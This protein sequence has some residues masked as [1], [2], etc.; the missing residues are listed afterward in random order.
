MI[1]TDTLRALVRSVL[2]QN[3]LHFPEE[4]AAAAFAELSVADRAMAFDLTC[5]EFVRRTMSSDSL[6]ARRGH[7]VKDPD[8][9]E[10]CLDENNL[11]PPLAER[12]SGV[13]ESKWRLRTHRDGERRHELMLQASTCVSRGVYKPFGEFTRADCCAAAH[14]RWGQSAANAV[15]AEKFELLEKMQADAGVDGVDKLSA[16]DL[17]I[18]KDF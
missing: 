16:E 13:R 11:V 18:Y 10:P 8:D 7:P 15:E 5:R 3:E 2:V 4:V 9:E 1:T 14:D 12:A 6:R 17:D